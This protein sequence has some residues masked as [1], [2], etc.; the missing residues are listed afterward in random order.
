MPTLRQDDAGSDEIER[1]RGMAAEKRA[2][3]I[4]YHD[5]HIGIWEDDVNEE[6]FMPIFRGI[7]RYLRRRGFVVTTDPITDKNFPVLKKKTRI[8]A[9]G[10]LEF[11]LRLSGRHAEI[12][13]F[14][15]INF[16]NSN[17]GRYDFDRYEKMPYLIK[18]SFLNEASRL[19]DFLMKNYGYTYGRHLEDHPGPTL[20]RILLCHRGLLDPLE[21]F[22]KGWT[23]ERFRRDETGWP[24]VEEYESSYNRCRDREGVPLRN[25]MVRYFRGDDGYLR[26]GKVYTNMNS[27]WQVVYGP[28]PKDT[29]YLSSGALF[30]LQPTDKHGRVVKEEKGDRKR[31]EALQEAIRAM[32]FERAAVLRDVIYGKNNAEAA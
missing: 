29:T 10:A 27:M 6:K 4:L 13:F 14:Q 8:G 2:G 3:S 5:T 16:V 21:R 12:E 20:Q 23:A 28:R 24:C 1:G 18:K 7:V 15:N 32:A 19:I 31:K 22:N 26:R 9:K 25:G 11:H 30:S 17:G